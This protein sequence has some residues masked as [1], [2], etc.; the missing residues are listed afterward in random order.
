MHDSYTSAK[1]RRNNTRPDTDPENHMT[2]TI[3]VSDEQR[4]IISTLKAAGWET[5]EIPTTT[6]QAGY[7][8]AWTRIGD[9]VV[10]VAINNGEDGE[11]EITNIP[12]ATYDEE[13]GEAWAWACG[14]T[15]FAK[16]DAD[17]T[18]AEALSRVA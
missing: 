9:Q 12:A 2:T 13:P 7:G 18:I 16:N 4:R 14:E 1:Q 3:N 10:F 17:G 6:N 11:N 8:G 15:G 5:T